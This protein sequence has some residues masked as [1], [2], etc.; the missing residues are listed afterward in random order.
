MEAWGRDPFV[1]ITRARS[2]RRVVREIRGGVSITRGRSCSLGSVGARLRASWN[3][4]Q[5]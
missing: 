3:E 1:M 2:R 5:R 4:E